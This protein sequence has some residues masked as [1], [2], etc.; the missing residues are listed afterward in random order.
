MIDLFGAGIRSGGMKLKT[1]ISYQIEEL[2]FGED[3]SVDMLQLSAGPLLHRYSTVDLG[4]VIV[5]YIQCA[6]SVQVRDIH[7]VPFLSFGIVTEGE[8]SPRF[9][10]HPL[11]R[12][13]TIVWRPGDR[14]DYEYVMPENFSG[15]VVMVSKET[16]EQRGWSMSPA[17]FMKASADGFNALKALS[18]KLVQS[19]MLRQPHIAFAFLNALE[20]AFGAQLFKDSKRSPDDDASDVFKIV[21]HA[22]RHISGLGP[23]EFDNVDEVARV[24]GLNRRSLYRAFRIWPGIGPARYSR[25]L[26]L[27]A[28]RRDLLARSQVESSVLQIALDNGF[29]HTGRFAAEY[30]DFFCENPAETLRRS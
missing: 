21:A 22:R 15:F 10:G 8:G 24:I 19:T 23:E 11:E 1:H 20:Q 30:R 27:A 12:G 26:R 2:Q 25:V 9:L 4:Q 14:F 16:A 28:A 6:A 29:R 5:E 3:W 18:D 13:D 17:R 7:N